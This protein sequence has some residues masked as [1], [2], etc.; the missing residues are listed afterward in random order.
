MGARLHLLALLVAGERNAHFDEVAHDL[1][2]VAPDIADLG[3]LRRLDLD[4]GRAR[5]LGEAPGNLRLADAGRADHQDVL[6]HH[7]LAQA[8]VELQAA[9]AVSQRDRNGALGV[10]LADDEAVEFGDDFAGRKVGH[11]VHTINKASPSGVSTRR[12]GWKPAFR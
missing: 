3:E 7:L 9:P 10:A 6:R 4:E 12:S 1:L 11:E 8:F 2:D 5:E